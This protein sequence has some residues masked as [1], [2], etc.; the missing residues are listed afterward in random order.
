MQNKYENQY[1]YLIDETVDRR[2]SKNPEVSAIIVTYNRPRIFLDCLASL[3]NQ[4]YKNFEIIVVDNGGNDSIKEKILQYNLLY[5]KMKENTPVL[6]ARTV[7]CFY[8]RSSYGGFIDDDAICD[9]HIIKNAIE[10]F[11]SFP[12]IVAASGRILPRSNVIYNKLQSHYDLGNKILFGHYREG[13]SFIKK[14]AWLELSFYS[15]CV[16]D[17]KLIKGHEG[18]IVIYKIGKKYGIKSFI[19]QPSIIIYHDYASNLKNFLKKKRSHKKAIE[20]YSK[21]F[22]E[23]INFVKKEYHPDI[24]TSC[25]TKKSVSDKILIR[26]INFFLKIFLKL[27]L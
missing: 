27:R 18:M 8:S 14:E 3:E 12:E 17:R 2:T 23:I 5:L 25:V 26:L 24:A 22:P 1:S 9:I 6:L 13:N 10:T 19:Y 11:K 4:S 16:F 21:N 7:G 20:N 15:N